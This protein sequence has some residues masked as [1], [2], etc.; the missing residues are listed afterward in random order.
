MIK[1]LLANAEDINPRSGKIPHGMRRLSLCI[2]TTASWAPKSLCPATREDT[3]MKNLSTLQRPSEAKKKKRHH[4]LSQWWAQTAGISLWHCSLA[5]DYSKL[6]WKEGHHPKK[7][8]VS[9]GKRMCPDD[10]GWLNRNLLTFQCIRLEGHKNK[11]NK[12]T[13]KIMI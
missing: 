9:P 4:G 2:T 13:Y 12:G 7:M 10:G 5:S 11:Q 6:S 3:A 8:G 1:N